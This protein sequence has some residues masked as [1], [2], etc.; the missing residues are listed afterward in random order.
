M[1]ARAP[2]ALNLIGYFRKR[3][4][5]LDQPVGSVSINV[6]QRE[7]NAGQLVLAGYGNIRRSN[8]QRLWQ[9]ITAALTHRRTSDCNAVEPTALRCVSIAVAYTR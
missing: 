4:G 6:K 7:K 1:S 5:V 3:A 8:L 9:P 2:S